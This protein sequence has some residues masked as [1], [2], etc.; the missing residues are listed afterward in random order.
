MKKFVAI[1]LTLGIY[2]TILNGQVRNVL[3]KNDTFLSKIKVLELWISQQMELRNIPGL[4]VG[5]VY[6]QEL[7]YA[8]GFGYADMKK[9]NPVTPRSLFRIASNSK[10]Y[11]ATA[12]MQLRDEGKLRLDDPIEKYLPGFS[13]GNPYPDAPEITI[14]HLLT[15]T[16]G[17]PR[18]A[19]FPYWTDRKFPTMKQILEKLPDQE[20]IYPPGTRYKYSNLGMALLG[21]VVASVS[22]VP[23][24]QYIT[25]QIF[26]PLGMDHSSVFPG[27]KDKKELVTPYSRSFPDGSRRV[28]PFTD[29]QG[30]AP[31]ANIT[32]NIEDL[33]RFV[34]LQFRAGPKGGNQILNGYTLAE[35]HRI[36]WLNKNWTSGYGLGFR[37]WKDDDNTVV[38]HGGW[39]AGNR[40]QISFIPDK[41]I[42]VVILTNADDVSPSFFANHFL[43]MLTPVILDEVTPPAAEEK[44]DPSWQKYVGHYTDPSWF[45]TDVI[46]YKNHLALYNYSYPPSDDPEG[47]IVLLTPVGKDTFRMDGPNGNGENVV[48]FMDTNNRVVK[49]KIGENFI[50]PG[51]PQK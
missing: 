42:G 6:D 50:F 38:G 10:T 4:A 51:K 16:S 43:H 33:A 31:A 5:V 2:T 19:G 17:L 24:E 20:M 47:G 1:V 46:L 13:I 21:Q 37:V 41:K 25:E 27:E 29:A 40:S 28:M 44:A 11:T 32:S 7:V 36:H 8:K 12:I 3:E 34:S 22:G 9:K 49:V 48:F 15:H 23:Y 45:D 26:Q 14:F 30:L 39:V 18:E 35:M